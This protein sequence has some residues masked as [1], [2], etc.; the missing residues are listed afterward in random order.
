MLSKN[1]VPVTICNFID[2]SEE[3]LSLYFWQKH[4]YLKCCSCEVHFDMIWCITK[5]LNAEN[6]KQ[7]CPI[8]ML[9]ALAV[10]K[11]TNTAV[12]FSN[13][14]SIVIQLECCQSLFIY[15]VF[16]YYFIFKSSVAYYLQKEC[17][18]KN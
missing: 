11:V 4:S 16:N 8:I 14:V 2:G 18:G 12:G 6:N 15:Y 10:N 13:N 1:A 7:V 5:C 17:N 9:R 3:D